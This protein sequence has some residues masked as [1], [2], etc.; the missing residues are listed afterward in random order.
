MCVSKE[1][2]KNLNTPCYSCLCGVLLQNKPAQVATKTF[3]L[4]LLLNEAD[5]ETRL[6]AAE[7]LPRFMLRRGFFLH[8]VVV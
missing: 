8:G 7:Q 3:L 2:K 5:L 4:I 6:Y 1:K